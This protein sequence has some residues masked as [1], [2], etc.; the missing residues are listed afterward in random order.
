MWRGFEGSASDLAGK[1]V[2]VVDDFSA[3]GLTLDAALYALSYGE[4][5]APS[6]FLTFDLANLDTFEKEGWDE[7]FEEY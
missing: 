5:N 4:K 6:K 1:P 7:Y 2:F 3:T